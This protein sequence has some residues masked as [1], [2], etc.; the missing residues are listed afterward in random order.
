[1]ADA[2]L[3]AWREEVLQGFGARGPALQELLTYNETPFTLDA[4][5]T[6]TLPL[7][8]EPHLLAWEEYAKEAAR[9]GPFAA[10]Q[11]RLVQ[12]RFPVAQGM[13]EDP[14]YRAATRRGVLPL[15]GG[16]GLPLRHPDTLALTL[17][18][19]ASGRIPTLVVGDRGDFVT[20]VQAMTGRNEPIPVPDSMGACIVTGLNNWDRVA[21]HRAAWEAE[22]GLAGDETAWAEEFRRLAP[23]KELYQDRFII[24]SSGPYSAVA[25]ADVGLPEAEWLAESIRIRREHEC[26]HYLTYRVFG[27]MRNNLLDEVIA[28]LVGLLHVRRRY[29]SDLALRFFGLEAF[30]VYRPGGR[31]ESY[32]GSPPLS[33]EA[34]GVLRGLVFKTVRHLEAFVSDHPDLREGVGRARLVLAL[35]TLTLEELAAD[36]MPLRLDVRLGA[37]PPAA[38]SIGHPERLLRMDVDGTVEGLASVLDALG[39]LTALHSCLPSVS[40]DFSVALDEVISNIVNHAP[41]GQGPYRVSV[42]VYDRGRAIEAVVADDAP[43]FNPLATP[44]P[45]L[46]GSMETRPVG[47]LGIHLVRRLMDT[48]EYRR[49]GG[50][51]RLLLRKDVTPAARISADS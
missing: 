22:T 30:P 44:E 21:R 1:M 48:V 6:V 8:D 12:L 39:R 27:A 26:T 32:L 50:W 4:A 43:H 42:E 41:P 18:P 40:G 45:L 28:D 25:A 10:L 13:S 9:D 34:V 31:L 36:A 17:N 23:R 51:N 14:D 2:S 3:N 16:P 7:P 20:L 11:S 47:G 35:A 37:L 19:T 46:D 49:E 33:S 24:L 15:G 5:A 29:E 38:A